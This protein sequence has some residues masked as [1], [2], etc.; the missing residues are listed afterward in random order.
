MDKVIRIT[1]EFKFETGHALYG[2]DGLCKNVHGH[3]YKLS[4]TLLG[5]PIA[6][7]DHVKYGMVMDFSDL[8]KIV[9]ETIVTP[10]DHATVLNVDSPHKELADTMESRGHKIMRVQYQPTSE[11]MVL[12]FAE[13]IKTRLP[14]Q[15]KLHHLILRETETSYA[16]WYA[17]D[18]EV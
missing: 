13:K 10:F 18:Q 17:S 7:P 5:T 4:V 12:D 11:M 6:D 8:K 14:E 2:Y 16:E 1:K 3:S 15:L 9:N